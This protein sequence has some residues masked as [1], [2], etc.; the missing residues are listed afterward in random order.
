MWGLDLAPCF[1]SSRNL[2]KYVSIVNRCIYCRLSVMGLDCFH[3]WNFFLWSNETVSQVMSLWLCF[4]FFFFSLQSLKFRCIGTPDSLLLI[5]SKTM[6]LRLNFRE[7]QQGW[8]WDVQS[9]PLGSDDPQCLETVGLRKALVKPFGARGHFGFPFYSCELF[10]L[11][12]RNMSSS[13]AQLQTLFDLPK[14]DT[15]L[16]NVQWHWIW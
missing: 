2:K 4:C 11:L 1:F 14:S 13:R 7:S 15:N 10:V 12:L 5:I 3:S 9:C 8:F 6:L 16:L